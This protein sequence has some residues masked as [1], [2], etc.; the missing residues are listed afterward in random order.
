MKKNIFLIS[1]SR[2]TIPPQSNS[3]GVPR[4]IQTFAENEFKDVSYK[5]V[6]Q[7]SSSLENLEYN[8]EKY[9]HPKVNLFTKLQEVIIRKV[10][11]YRVKKK[12]YGYTLADRIIY[13]KGIKK[14]LRKETPDVIITFMHFELFKELCLSFPKVKH[15]F[16]YRST[17]LM[18]RIGSN[19]IRFIA[20]KGSG[21]LANTKS[22]VDEFEKYN[23]EKIPTQTIYNATSLINNTNFSS[24]QI[25]K[26]FRKDNNI[27]ENE[28]VLGYAGRFSEEKSLIEI[29]E[30]LKILK[31]NHG[32]IVHLLIAG[33]INN[34]KTP[35]FDYYNRVKNKIDMY[36][37]DQVHFVG[38]VTHSNLFEFYSKL[39]LGVLFS[40][41][42]EGNSMF[43]IEALSMGV[44]VLATNIGGNKE[45]VSNTLNGY[46]FD[47]DGLIAN[48][49]DKILELHNDKLHITTMS[50]EAVKY[51]LKH[52]TSNVMVKK[53]NNFITQ[54]FIEK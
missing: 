27:P 31:E 51:T 37:K 13:Y 9:L 41:Y 14:T 34:E 15:V 7:Y 11:P 45:I 8:K 33:D 2:H 46:L 29:L 49:V 12:W 25:Y 21:F 47:I 32:L 19:A 24:D 22:A 39:D 16:F 36:L 18:G 50:N 28:I 40:K 6:S 38:W 4:I 48:L 52:H 35:D 44:P 23:V 42:R 30:A 54:N 1:G 53:F 17:D 5:V 26:R 20:N 3:P 43:L 10:L